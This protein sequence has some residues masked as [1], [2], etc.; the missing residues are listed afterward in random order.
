MVFDPKWKAIVRRVEKKLKVGTQ[1]EVTT[2]TEKP[3]MKGTYEDPQIMAS[4]GV[5]ATQANAYNV[6]K[7]KEM[8]E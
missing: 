6:D 4:I 1:P 7:L 2:V 8:V 3:V 5:V